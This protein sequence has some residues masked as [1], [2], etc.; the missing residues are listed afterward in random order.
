MEIKE[1]TPIMYSNAVKISMS[2]YDFML[3][4][5]LNVPTM[6]PKT[7]RVVSNILPLATFTMSPQHF[8]AFVQLAV[9]QLGE[10]EKQFGE[11]KIVKPKEEKTRS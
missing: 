9:K 1:T 4:L 2:N 7:Q 5:G 10:Y 6:D 11:I 3:D 8:K